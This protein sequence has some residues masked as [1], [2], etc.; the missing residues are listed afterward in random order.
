[1]AA[2]DFNSMYVKHILGEKRV[3]AVSMVK[4]KFYSIQA[5]TTVDGLKDTDSK[6]DSALIFSLFV[7]KSK[8]IVHCI[9]I[10]AV[11]PSILKRFFK[12][13]TNLDTREIELAGT[14]RKTYQSVV[15]KFPGI[16]EN[17]YRT[18]K[19]SGIKKVV[20]INMDVRYVT[21]ARD[22]VVGVNDK[23]QVQNK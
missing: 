3:P 7:S 22:K 13:L 19:I 12:R 9:K 1:M 16:Q 10:S 20:E 5:Y 4:S 23:F 21:S 6:G 17:A 18:Y 11:N 15:S 14:A 2:R 8:D